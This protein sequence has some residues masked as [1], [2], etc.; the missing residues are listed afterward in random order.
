MNVNYFLKCD[1][2]G[3]IIQVKIQ[4]GWLEQ[5]PIRIHCG[6]CGILI[7]GEF[8]TN[9]EKITYNYKYENAT[10]IQKCL[11]DFYI[12]SSG[13]LLTKKIEEYKPNESIKYHIP[14]FFNSQWSMSNENL[15][16]FRKNIVRFLYGIKKTWPKYR[17]IFELWNMGN[18]QYM[19]QE[20]FK[21]LPKR[22]YPSDNN[23]EILRSMHSI[24][25]TNFFILYD[26]EFFSKT[27]HRI[28]NEILK[29][30]IHE[31]KELI[32]YFEN[33]ECLFTLYQEKISN[34]LNNFIKVFDFLI[35]AYGASFY[36]N[37]IDFNV[38]G[39]TTCSFEDIKQFYL[40]AYE[41]IGEM[42]MLTISLNNIKYRGEF[43]CVQSIN[44]KINSMDD[45]K[46]ATKGIRIQYL[47]Q[48]EFFTEIMKIELNS[49]LRNAIGH[50]NYKYNGVTQEI[51]YIPNSQKP[52]KTQS[53]FLLEF[54]IEC[55]NLVKG[56]IIFDEI[57]YQVRKIQYIEEGCVP[58]ITS[59]DF[60]D[61]V[62]RN[63]KCPCGSGLKYKKC[64]GE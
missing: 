40:D 11:P 25:M 44:K 34:V 55:I 17:R 31:M 10:F 9:Q 62:G 18:I 27:M 64:H 53:I 8:K 63:E 13:E 29:I 12:E 43:R 52:D 15:L 37:E 42:L 48:N 45:L 47:N 61:K 35:P 54:A 23:I 56:L 26:Q 4:V 33:N 36:E 39:S 6:K 16:Q 24:Q 20:I 50:N 3:A 2:C 28:N 32:K 14:P 59:K 30:D 19:Q 21:Y 58:K 38:F 7:S 41:A 5:H 49:K 22:L 60:M 46:T 1:V 51:I 57:L